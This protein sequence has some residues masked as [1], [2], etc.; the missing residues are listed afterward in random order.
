[1]KTVENFCKTTE[2]PNEHVKTTWGQ[3]SGISPTVKRS[4]HV[5]LFCE[6]MVGI[7]NVDLSLFLKGF[8]LLSRYPQS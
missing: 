4:A 7:K 1:M 3:K 6:H 8:P 5:V 2:Y